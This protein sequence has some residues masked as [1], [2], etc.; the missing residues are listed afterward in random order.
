MSY[1]LNEF[2]GKEL[3]VPG[4]WKITAI[5]GLS[6]SA[7]APVIISICLHMYHTYITK[8]DDPHRPRYCKPETMN[9]MQHAYGALD[10]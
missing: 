5:D 9:T 4:S 3:D 7:Q 6:L 2:R 1:D 8:P 10:R